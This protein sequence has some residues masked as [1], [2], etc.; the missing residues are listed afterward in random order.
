M[1][2]DNIQVA[3]REFFADELV[4]QLGGEEMV[5]YRATQDPHDFIFKYC[6]TLDPHDPVSPVKLMPDHKYLHV[7]VDK[8]RAHNLLL[9]VKSRQ[10][11]ATWIMCALHL[12]DCM[13]HR[14]RIAFLVSKNENDANYSRELSLLSRVSFMYDHL[15]SNLRA[16][17]M[18][19]LKPACFKFPT[20]DSAIYGMSQDSDALR[21]YTATAVF[22]DEMAFHEHAYDAYAAVKPTLMG[23]GKLCG[24]STPNGK[25]NL[26]YD[27]VNNVKK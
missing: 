17:S 21:Q 8:W 24:V 16:R 5:K 14:G 3:S 27:L 10:M 7:I 19:T 9:I 13:I 1:A 18:K 22:W 23:G 2:L 4:A 15:P 26:F 11:M 20:M 12:W 6:Y 25:T